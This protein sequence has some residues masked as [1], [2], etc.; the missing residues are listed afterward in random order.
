MN[1]LVNSINLFYLIF[2]KVGTLDTL[3]GLSDELHKLDIFVEGWDLDTI[4]VTSIP[5]FCYIEAPRC[6]LK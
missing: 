3:I 1:I 5:Q 2:K 4:I 6:F